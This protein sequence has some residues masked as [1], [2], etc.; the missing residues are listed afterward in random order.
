M[1]RRYWRAALVRG[2]GPSG[3][4]QRQVERLRQ[5]P[6]KFFEFR[7]AQPSNVRCKTRFQDAHKFVAMYAGIVFQSLF[8]ADANLRRK[9]VVLGING[10]TDDGRKTRIDHQ[11]AADNHVYAF[12][13]RVERITSLDKVQITASH[14]IRQGLEFECIERFLIEP[15]GVCLVECCVASTALRALCSRQV[16]S[17]RFFQESRPVGIGLVNFRQQF[18]REEN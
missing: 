18:L 15:F 1:K 10:R 5:C 6:V 7:L 4:I 13:S 12:F 3:I 8:S 16:V 2:E 11:L 14:L 9:P 17:R